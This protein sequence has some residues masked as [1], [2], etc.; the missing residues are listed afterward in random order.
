MSNKHEKERR[1]AHSARHTQSKASPACKTRSSAAKAQKTASLSPSQPAPPNARPK[2]KA[3]Y[4]GSKSSTTTRPNMPQEEASTEFPAVSDAVQGLLDLRG[5]NPKSMSPKPEDEII[6]G[7]EGEEEVSKHGKRKR[8]GL[9]SKGEDNDDESDS[10]DDKDNDTEAVFDIPFAVPL[11]GAM[12]TLVIKSNVSWTDLCF[13]LADAMVKP[14]SQL[15]LRYKYS[16]NARNMAPNHLANAVHLPEL[17]EG[18]KDGLEAMACAKS[19]ARANGKKPKPFKV[20]I[21]DLDAGK[22][23]GKVKCIKAKHKKKKDSSESSDSNEDDDKNANKKKHKKKGQSQQA[24]IVLPSGSH[25]QLTMVD[26]S[27]WGMMMTQD[28]KSTTVP[29]RQLRLEDANPEGTKPV[30]STKNSKPPAQTT[31]AASLSRHPQFTPTPHQRRY[32]YKMPSSDPPEL[33]DPTLFP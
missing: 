26:K 28:H 31:P 30:R 24:C 3:A 14:A 8:N 18:A 12:D 6:T 13:Q 29:P 7:S 21:T 1:A 23:K 5:G 27:L 17:I 33:D 22:D 11:D 4:K 16:T 19:K 2:P 25:Y 10:S 9:V 15:N 32:R 20:E